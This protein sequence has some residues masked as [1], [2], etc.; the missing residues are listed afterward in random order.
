MVLRE[1]TKLL[2]E[3]VVVGYGVQKKKLVT[4]ATIQV[5]GEKLSK[6]NTVDAFGALQSQAA[7]VQ[8]TQNS[9]EPG[10]GYKINIRGLGT[11]GSAAPLYVIDGVAGGNISA[12]SPNDIE[13]IDILKDAASAAIYGA[14]A[15]NGVILVTTKQGKAGK[16]SITYDGYYG[17][18]SSQTNGIRPANAKEYMTLINK[19]LDCA[20]TQEY[21][22]ESLIPN[23]YSKIMNGTWNGTN[24]LKE[25]T[26]NKA[27]IIS[28]AINL[29]GGSSLLVL[30]L[31]FLP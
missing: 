20:G 24:W 7:G 1:D 9:G 19:A 4:G 23:E 16:L 17:I 14:R 6:L 27:P 13:S 31:A 2:D 22:F 11:T 29:T 21:D 25:S 30:H 5:T 15:A 10:E 12:L 28:N 26:D 3:V 18:Q 8:I